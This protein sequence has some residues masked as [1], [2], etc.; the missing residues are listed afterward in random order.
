MLPAICAGIVIFVAV[1]TL[2][3]KNPMTGIVAVP[4][5]F[6]FCVSLVVPATSVFVSVN[7]PS[8][9]ILSVSVVPS[10]SVSLIVD[11]AVFAH[12]VQQG[13]CPTMPLAP[14]YCTS[15]VT[16]LL[17]VDAY[18]ILTILPVVAGN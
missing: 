18:P 16:P 3:P 8:A 2:A 13:T 12:P 6:E 17:S 1:P 14:V 10:G 7:E 11:C 15:S 4:G 9:L 5:A